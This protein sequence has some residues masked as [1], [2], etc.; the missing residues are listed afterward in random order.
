MAATRQQVKIFIS[1]Q[2][3]GK[4]HASAVA[5]AGISER[6]GRRLEGTGTRPARNPRHWRTRNDP[7]AAVWAEVARQLGTEP[8]LQALTLL[9]WLQERY[10]GQYPDKL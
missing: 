4:T 5:K 3:Q 7:F 8:E 9:E 6:T 2:E 1:Q 10:P